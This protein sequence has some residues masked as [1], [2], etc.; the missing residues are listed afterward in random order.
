MKQLT[1]HLIT[2]LASFVFIIAGTH[3]AN[4]Q[5]VTSWNGV[6]KKV[7]M[8]AG[9][10]KTFSYKATQQGTLYIMAPTAS[11][12]LGLTIS[13]G[14]YH[15]GAIDPDAQFDIAEPYDNG[16][17][18]F[19]TIRVCAGDEIRFTIEAAASQG[20][21]AVKQTS[22]TLQSKF[23]ADNYGGSS[24]ESPIELPLDTLV[25]FPIYTNS[26]PDYLSGFSH[27]TFA[28]FVAPMDGLASIITGEYLI[29]YINEDEYGVTPM[30]YAVQAQMT[31]DHEF[32][33]ERGQAYIVMIP[34]TR[35]TSVT[36]KFTADHPGQLATYPIELESFPATLSLTNNDA[37]W[38]R[39]DVSSLGED[40]MLEITP[41]GTWEGSIEYWNNPNNTNTWLSTDSLQGT[42]KSIVKN[43]NPNRLGTTKYLY[44][45]VATTTLTEEVKSFDIRLRKPTAGEDATTATPIEAGDT[46]V[47]LDK[48]EQWYAF[49]A[50]KDAQLTITSSA[51]LA[52]LCLGTGEA[53]IINEFNTYRCYEGDT[54]H[55]CLK[56]T[57]NAT[58]TIS[59]VESEL[60]LGDYCD[61]PID[62]TL[63]T[64][65]V[66]ADRGEQIMNYRR[67]VA[68]ESGT[69]IFKTTTPLWVE[70][71][72]SVVFRT[73][74]DGKA[75]DFVRSEFEDDA[76]GDLG[77]SYKLSVTKGETY[78]IEIT[79]FT[80]GGQDA[81]LKT[82]FQRATDGTNYETALPIEALGQEIEIPNTPNLTRWYTYTAN[83]TGFYTIKSKI[84]QGSTMRIMTGENTNEMINSS[85]D[86]SY[87][88]AYMA[89]RKVVKVYAEQGTPIY[90]CIS[91]SS[92]PGT[93]GGTDRHLSITFA[94]ARE[95]EYFGQPIVASPDTDYTLPNDE[96]TAYDTWYVFTIP[97]GNEC[98]FHISSEVTPSYGSLQFHTDEHTAVNATSGLFTMES[99]RDNAGQLCGKCYTFAPADEA[100]TIYIKTEYQQ[101]LHTWSI[102]LNGGDTGINAV[103]PDNASPAA[104]LYTP[105]GVQ[106]D[107]DYKGIVIKD[108]KKFIQK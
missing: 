10:T 78:I 7:T 56:P 57:G 53:S 80:N 90:V 100:R 102:T 64:D 41:Q 71:T 14:W 34:I 83:Q 43:L 44:L 23:F 96:A 45:N 98:I 59:I 108:G 72:W 89:G 105:A 106:V 28:R 5:S 65:I 70:N 35:P 22:F 91:I 15:D 26:S 2:L 61:L 73:D 67:F 69:A 31:D 103:T 3:Q 17:G 21:D 20:A 93:T 9:A 54:Y 49:T 101:N 79:S 29:Y 50:T 58:D 97:A 38:Y 6:D 1:N 76:T 95:G 84:G 88:N 27:T 13:G 75:L 4:A 47:T 32:V 74:C 86:N 37:N 85:T 19:A 40:Y 82:S 8:K 104:P 60:T 12:G 62:F 24:W 48:P 52:Y 68:E 87:E 11:T 94:E 51:Q 81:I 42:G 39:M 36:L 55:L 99:I 77:L 25:E 46:Q 63:G 30:K 66:V 107:Y 33:V 16:A 18:I 92:T